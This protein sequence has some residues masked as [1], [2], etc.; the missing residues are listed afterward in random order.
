MFLACAAAFVCHREGGEGPMTA[1]LVGKSFNMLSDFSVL[2]G[3]WKAK[4]D[5]VL[6]LVSQ[7]CVGTFRDM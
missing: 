4:F 2:S 1:L 7:L 3:Y 6:C 5:L